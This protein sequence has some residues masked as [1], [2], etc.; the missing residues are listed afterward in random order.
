MVEQALDGLE[1]SYVKRITDP[2]AE[3]MAVANGDDAQA[4][5][6]SR[7][8]TGRR[9][10]DCDGGLCRDAELLE[11]DLIRF[12]CGLYHLDILL[13]DDRADALDQAGGLEHGL[14]ILTPGSRHHR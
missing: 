7:R 11:R 1:S 6:A 3:G 4:G 8:N 5:R 2:I 9:I 10:F 13:G 12:R 14:N